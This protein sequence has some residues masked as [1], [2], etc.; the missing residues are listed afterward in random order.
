MRPG[1]ERVYE[2]VCFSNM[3]SVYRQETLVT[4]DISFPITSHVEFFA[5]TEMFN[6]QC[7][8]ELE[9]QLETSNLVV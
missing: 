7:P 5:S 8:T 3:C 6:R 1:D 2:A 4:C 9:K